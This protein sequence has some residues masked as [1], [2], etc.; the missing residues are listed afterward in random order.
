MRSRCSFTILESAS[1]VEPTCA[2]RCERLAMP[3]IWRAEPRAAPRLEGEYPQQA[4]NARAV[5]DVLAEQPRRVRA[6]ALIQQA[7]ATPEGLPW[8]AGCAHDEPVLWSRLPHLA[9]LHLGGIDLVHSIEH[10]TL[11][12]LVLDDRPIRDGTRNFPGRSP[13]LA[14]APRHRIRDDPG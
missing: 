14:L 8:N 12:H 4:S 10:P 13:R 2:A 3:T 9:Q 1:A 11:A 6:L 7:V 5:I